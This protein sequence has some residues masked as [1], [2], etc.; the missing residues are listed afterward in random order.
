ML[1]N[2]EQAS[3]EQINDVINEENYNTRPRRTNAGT[4]VDRLQMSFD[5]KAYTHGKERQFLIVD[6]DYNKDKDM[7]TY[8]SI[9]CDVMFTQMSA[10][11]GIKMFG[12]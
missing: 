9:A 4:G 8:Y 2:E 11:K 12:E 10:K 7:N 1:E 6:E 3:V 5:G